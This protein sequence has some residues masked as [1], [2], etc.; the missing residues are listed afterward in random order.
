[1]TP[2]GRLSVHPLGCDGLLAGEPFVRQRL[3]DYR[4]VGGYPSGHDG[5]PLV[6]VV[7]RA[8]LRGRGGAAFPLW[9]KLHAV[10]EAADAAGVAPVV[11]AN[12][13]EG[14]P[15]SVKD[16]YLQRYRPHLVLEGT[17]LAMA[18]VGSE[19]AFVYVADA[20]A[21][22][23]MRAAVA[24]AAKDDLVR[25]EVRCVRAQDTYVAGE[26]TAAVQAIER[27]VARPTDKPPRPFQSGIGGVPTLVSNVETLAAAARH[28]RRPDAEVTFLCTLS[29]RSTAPALVELPVGAP[30]KEVLALASREVDEAADVLLGGFFGGMIPL[31]PDL[32]LEQETL[33]A[34]GASLGCGAVRLIEAGEC[35]VQ[36]AA[37]VAA[38]F[39]DNNARQCGTCIKTTGGVAAEL[40]RLGEPGAFLRARPRLTRWAETPPGA[41]ACALPDGLRVLLR[42]LLRHYGD[43]LNAHE[44]AGCGACQSAAETPRRWAH[45][46][47]DL[48][49]FESAGGD[50][51]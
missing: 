13:A 50:V 14:E 12:G 22:E 15:L 24:E 44:A 19:Q 47:V 16:R 26:E 51:R 11:V 48:P 23:S 5:P 34:L 40:A 30:A 35:P 7:H 9:R 37:D 20:G 41:G 3:A 17:L 46:R 33:A 32:E 6:E 10:R 31:E 42:S 4:A 38:Y 39:R 36:L 8:G 1:M 45:L 29:S 2:R 49:A 25:G 21:L 27:G 28:R 43:E 18:A